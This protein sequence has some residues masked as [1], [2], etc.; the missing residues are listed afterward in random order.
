VLAAAGSLALVAAIVAVVASAGHGRHPS[1]AGG[2]HPSPP[3]RHHAVSH[4]RPTVRHPHATV[5]PPSGRPVP[6][7]FS[8]ASF[9]AIDE[10][11][12]WLLGS[13]RCSGGPCDAIV[14]TTDGGRSFTRIPS[15]GSWMVG[16]LRFADARNG[17][18]FGPELWV[19]HDGGQHWRQIE[20]GG[21][22][23]DLAVS[24]GSVYAILSAQA[25]S[26]L[27]RSTVGSD[28][29]TQLTGA[30][31]AFSGLWAQGSD[32]L[33][34]SADQQKQS[35]LVSADRG[36]SFA[37]YPVPPNVACHF[38]APA[39]PVVWAH[40]A[41]GMQSGLWRSAD[42]GRSFAPVSGAH[43]WPGPELPN[44]AAF[45]AASGS[46][47]VLGY[48][49]LFRTTDSGNSWGPV[50]GTAGAG[51]WEYLGFTDPTHGAG[52]AGDGRT[53][54]LYYTTDGGASYHRVAIG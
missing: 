13:A 26:R 9:T 40:C 53:E 4:R 8:P 39:P 43:G 29:W 50:A 42:G 25:G 49:Q 6:S 31:F 44:S 20:L 5:P 46:T 41:T 21:T 22:V 35:L 30:K 51:Y 10:L 2:H 36:E 33:L 15:P 7:G 37:A 14:R 54:H 48:S 34:E 17:F 28:S 52:I 11:D 45:A 47:A 32:V 19:T 24:D 1:P 12:W 27:L 23:V 18:A 16:Q 3:P 38:E